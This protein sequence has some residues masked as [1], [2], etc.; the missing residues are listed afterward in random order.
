[1][2]AGHA[3][4]SALTGVTL[5]FTIMAGMA[6]IVRLYTRIAIVDTAGVDDIAIVVAMVTGRLPI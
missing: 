4:G 2:G 3:P 6:T 1:M 5:A